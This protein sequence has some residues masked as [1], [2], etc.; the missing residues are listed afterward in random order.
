MFKLF[1]RAK[2][3]QSPFKASSLALKEEND[4]LRNELFLLKGENG[5]NQ[6][7]LSCNMDIMRDQD[8]EIIV[9]EAIISNL[10]KQKVYAGQKFYDPSN[11]KAPT[12]YLC[13]RWNEWYVVRAQNEAT[14]RLITASEFNDQYG[15][16]VLM[17]QQNLNRKMLG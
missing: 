10:R 6:K 5:H 13:A 12:V 16:Y 8:Q 3:F 7:R 11:H 2:G 17:P 9:L 1:N 14:P 4:F 15:S